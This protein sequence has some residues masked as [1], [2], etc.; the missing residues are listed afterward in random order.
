MNL[1]QI[2]QLDSVKLG[3]Q[4]TDVFGHD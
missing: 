2:H 4:V 3:T 1:L